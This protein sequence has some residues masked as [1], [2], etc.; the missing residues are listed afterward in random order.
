MRFAN[1]AA[2]SSTPKV[3]D[4]KTTNLAGSEAYAKSPCAELCSVVLTSMLQS[5]YY[6]NDVSTMAR[7]R[8]LV[9][10]TS[11]EFAAKLALYARHEHG[12]RTISHVL[13]A[14]VA[15]FRYE[16]RD[17]AVGPALKDWGARFFDKIIKRP[18]DMVE[19]VAYLLSTQFAGRTKLTLPNA[20]KR[21]FARA[22]SR[23]SEYDLAKYGR[24]D[25]HDNKKMT[26]R[27][28]A[29]L[30]H[31]AG[32]KDSP[33]YKLRGATLPAPDTHEAVMTR[34]GSVAKAASDAG[35]AIDVDD[36]KA[37]EWARLFKEGKIGYLAALR[38]LRRIVEQAP[39]SI[40]EV[41]AIV[42]DPAKVAKALVFPFNFMAAS[43]AMAEVNGPAAQK[44]LRAIHKA[45]E[46]SVANVPRFEGAT[47]VVMDESG[48]MDRPIV[49][50]RGENVV[51]TGRS[52]A[53]I[54]SLFAAC[55]LKANDDADFML[56]S[57]D[58]RYVNVV[59]SDSVLSI[60]ATI[61][62]MKNPRGTNFNA[63]FETANRAYD[64]I[65]ILSDEQG[66]MGG[67][68]PDVAV[69]E[70]RQRHNADP[71]IYSWDL[72]G[73]GTSQFPGSKTVQLAGWT[74]KVFDLMK[75]I[76]MNPNE[77]IDAV[78]ATPL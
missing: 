21:G 45:M 28:V 38:N 31:A 14:E 52:P 49:T 57:T 25:A 33:V 54:A 18:D 68:A 29:H 66:W 48:S 67:K 4:K 60:A 16:T 75:S 70:Y 20:I 50:V 59:T 17:S 40:D 30:V 19:I 69:R 73:S 47:L 37:A 51:N 55:L 42:A 64:R 34:A 23:C 8:K 13:A 36:L 63:P 46:L 44:A 2:R 15:L 26:L 10:Q 78:S 39:E 61:R 56:F 72:M 62:A 3:G 9:R 12:L 71:A 43:K 24:A 76:E 32:P 77:M 7:L 27:R 22:F 65:I 11:P 5:S 58:A 41:C 53:D 35:E 74:D 1:Q 6:A